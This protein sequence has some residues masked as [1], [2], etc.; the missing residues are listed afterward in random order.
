MKRWLLLGLAMIFSFSACTGSPASEEV[1]LTKAPSVAEIVDECQLAVAEVVSWRQ[2]VSINPPMSIDDTELEVMEWEIMANEEKQ[3]VIAVM[4]DGRKR[5]GYIW[6]G[7]YRCDRWNEGSWEITAPLAKGSGR[8]QQE[9]LFEQIFAGAENLALV[10]AETVQGKTC[11]IIEHTR[12][13]GE[14]GGMHFRS[15]KS[16][17]WIDV[18]SYLCL[19]RTIEAE[20]TVQIIEYY[21]YN[22][23]IS[24]EMPVAAPTAELTPAVPEDIEWLAK[25]IA[26]EAGS[27]WDVDRWVRCT[28]EERSAVGWTVLNR[29]SSGTFGQTVKEVVTA[30]AQYAHNQEPTSEIRELARKLLEGQIPDATGGATHFFSPISMPKQGE[31]TTGFDVEGGLHVVPGIAKKVYFPSWTKTYTWVGDLNSVRRAYFMFYQLAGI[32]ADQ[33]VIFPDPNLEAAIREAI[34]K[35]EGTIYISDLEGLASLDASERDITD[36]TGLEYCV[37]LERLW[38]YRNQ[39]SDVSP[40]ASLTDLTGVELNWNQIRDISPL[41]LLTNV[42]VLNMAHNQISDISPLGSLA[43]LTMLFLDRNQITDVSPLV[44][45]TNLTMLSLWKNEISDIKSLVN[46]VGLSKGDTVRLNFNPLST[47][48]VDVYIP[49]LQERG[50]DVSW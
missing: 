3:H 7:N 13:A 44:S 37:N 19:K 27:V 40:L 16:K 30:P 25:V 49:Q 18:N 8:S 11:Y 24:F 21:D 22:A 23:P 15:H 34:S 2:R 36:L 47:T 10:G 26:S 6:S 17:M 31:S 43:N 50:V 35:S 46:N 14:Y 33:E 29:V 45:L 48:S 28:D 12:P 42:I 41:A 4:T 39:I 1:D 38:L 20:Q 32:T 5:E 9:L